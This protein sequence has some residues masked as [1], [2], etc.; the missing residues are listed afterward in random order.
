MSVLRLLGTLLGVA[1]LLPSCKPERP[2][3]KP[4]SPAETPAAAPPVAAAP[5]TVTATD[6][7]LDLPDTLPAGAVT[8]QLVNHGKELHQAQVVRLEGGK[9]MADFQAAMKHEGPPPPW[10]KFVGGPN[11]VAPGQE[12]SSTVALTPG[13][14]VVICLIPSTDGVPH[15]MKGMIHPLAVTSMATA[16]TELPAADDTVRL[17]DYKF[18]SSRPFSSGRHVILVENAA[19]QPHELV[20]LQLSP[21]KTTADFG[22]W[23]T[24]G[25]MKGRPPAMPIGGVGVIDPGASGTFPADLA[26]GSYG[27]ICFVPDAKDGKPHLVHGMMKDFKVE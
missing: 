16:V 11:G 22:R 18:D 15:L 5:V 24:T 9:T 27:L 12:A 23:A 14:Y 21:G 1:V 13:N 26:P 20:L 25:G 10:L 17:G 6:F 8:L 19:Q 3:A 4:A 2:A 7:K